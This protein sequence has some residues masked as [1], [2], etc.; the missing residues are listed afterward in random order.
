MI[1]FTLAH[2]EL[3]RFMTVSLF[4]DAL[5]AN[6]LDTIARTVLLAKVPYVGIVLD[7]MKR[8]PVNALLQC[9]VLTASE[10]TNHL[11]S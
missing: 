1:E 2:K 6:N 7:L 9:V 5:T 10:M 8:D 3:V 4:L 11:K